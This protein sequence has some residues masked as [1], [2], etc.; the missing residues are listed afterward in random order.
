VVSEELSQEETEKKQM[1]EEQVED[2]MDF[3]SSHPPTQTRIQRF[4][5]AS[6]KM[7][8]AR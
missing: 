4:I 7:H 3:M 2:I 1:G 8:S 5:D 6:E